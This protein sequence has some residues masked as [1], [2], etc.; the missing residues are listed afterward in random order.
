MI[1]GFSHDCWR[2]A[3]SDVEDV[4]FLEGVIK[5]E[6]EEGQKRLARVNPETVVP[7]VVFDTQKTRLAVKEVSA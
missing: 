3:E 2:C 5:V 1:A 7:L 4:D 6:G